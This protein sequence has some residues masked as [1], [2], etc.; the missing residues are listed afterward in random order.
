MKS[1][2]EKCEPKYPKQLLR[3]NKTI[4]KITLTTNTAVT[5]NFII[6]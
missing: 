2:I 3:L 4:N 6:N 5:S 1:L